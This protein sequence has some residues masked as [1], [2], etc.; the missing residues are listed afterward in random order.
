MV[1]WWRRANRQERMESAGRSVRFGKD[2]D[3]NARSLE[4]VFRYYDEKM[5][6]YERRIKEL[7]EG[8]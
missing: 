4:Q 5:R 1:D 2:E 6:E 8:A 3:V 7:E